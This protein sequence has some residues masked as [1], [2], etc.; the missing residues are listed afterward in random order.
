MIWCILKVDVTDVGA[1]EQCV[2]LARVRV[3]GAP[4]KSGSFKLELRLS[5]RWRNFCQW[6]DIGG[7]SDTFVTWSFHN[8]ALLR[9]T[10]K[11]VF[12]IFSIQYTALRRYTLWFKCSFWAAQSSPRV[13]TP[14]VY[15][16]ISFLQHII[17]L[18]ALCRCEL[19]ARMQ[20]RVC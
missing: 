1:G 9:S 17:I 15:M 11:L 2:M 12:R 14:S 18:E 3:W 6:P 20:E 7:D 19:Y 10:A 4:K 8:Y 16:Y 5:L 13:L